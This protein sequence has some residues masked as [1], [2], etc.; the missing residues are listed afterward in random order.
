[1]ETILS[2]WYPTNNPTQAPTGEKR[3]ILSLRVSRRISLIRSKGLTTLGEA[4]Q[5]EPVVGP[6]AACSRGLTDHIVAA[7]ELAGESVGTF[8]FH[9]SYSPIYDYVADSRWLLDQP[10]LSTREV[11]LEPRFVVQ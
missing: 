11:G 6:G 10:L 3:A 5:F 2:P 1:M 7:Q 9:E 4:F 8:V